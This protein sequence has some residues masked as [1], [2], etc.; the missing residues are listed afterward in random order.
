MVGGHIEVFDEIFIAGAAATGA[1]A[2][3][4]LHFILSKRCALDVAKVRDGDDH[5]LVGDGV[6]HAELSGAVLDR[7]AAFITEALLDVLQFVFDD[8]HTEVHVGEHVLQVRDEFHQFIVFV[9]KLL[10]LHAGE[11]A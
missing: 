1:L 2:A 8:T 4:V 10:A 5:L 3:T 11:L 6:L 9:L 7:G